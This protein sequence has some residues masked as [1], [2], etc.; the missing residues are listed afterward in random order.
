MKK[1]FYPH[2]PKDRNPDNQ[3]KKKF[4]PAKGTKP[5]GK[6]PAKF[7]PQPKALDKTK[8][9]SS[10]LDL[11]IKMGRWV[12]GLHAA[13][14]VLKM[15]PHAVKRMLIREDWALTPQLKELHELAGYNDI[16]IQEKSSGQIDGLL[17]AAQAGGGHQG[18]LLIVSGRPEIDWKSLET[19][20]QSV[21]LALDGLEDPQNLGSILRTS[22]LMSVDG[23]LVPQDRA[24]G[25][26]PTV[27]KVASGGAEHVAIE[28]VSNMG[29]EFKHMK[30]MGYWIFGLSEKGEKTIWDLKL[31]EKIVWVI[32]NEASGMRVSTEKFCDELVRIPQAETGSSYNA[33]IAAAIALAESARQLSQQ[34]KPAKNRPSR[35]D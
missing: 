17:S 9:K 34:S 21:L 3:H 6:L 25:L 24:A 20:E 13:Q 15:R 29:S 28:S 31:P 32:G 2:P 14:E 16:Q 35:E 1:S 11:F 27:S 10:E 18:I 19:K 12:I 30:D 23:I 8:Q 5:Q 4:V 26:T 33:G 22:W 7:Q